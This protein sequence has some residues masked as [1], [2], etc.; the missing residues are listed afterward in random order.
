MAENENIIMKLMD[1]L[2]LAIIFKGISDLE[3]TFY[4][5]Y[6]FHTRYQRVTALSHKSK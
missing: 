1:E 2:G 6:I 4:G 3:D 5:P